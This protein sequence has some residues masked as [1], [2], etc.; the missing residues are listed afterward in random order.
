MKKVTDILKNSAA[1]ITASAA[2]I[3]S[4]CTIRITEDGIDLGG[5]SASSRQQREER[6]DEREETVDDKEITLEGSEE[7][8][9]TTAVIIGESVDM[10]ETDPAVADEIAAAGEP[11]SY[12]EPTAAAEVAAA[13]ATYEEVVLVDND[14]TDVTVADYNDITDDTSWD[15]KPGYDDPAVNTHLDNFAYEFT[16][17][18]EYEFRY[19]NTDRGYMTVDDGIG[20]TVVIRIG[21]NAYVF[22]MASNGY[23]DHQVGRTFLMGN[24]GHVYFYI[25]QSTYYGHATHV[26]ELRDDMI[27][28]IGS[29][30]KFAV[31]D[32]SDPN[33]FEGDLNSGCT[34]IFMSRLYRIDDNGMPYP[35]NEFYYFDSELTA[36]VAFVNDLTGNIIR[37]GVVTEDT[38]TIPAGTYIDLVKTNGCTYID[39]LYGSDLVRVDWSDEFQETADRDDEYYITTAI[40][41]HLLGYR[42]PWS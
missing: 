19:L 12:E 10:I 29:R 41:D 38:V 15:P 18:D 40:T 8:A 33:W 30:A 17:S 32:I 31:Y 16:Y 27:Y 9:G 13:E 2:L 24:N 35:V 26:Y 3:T 28:Y 39:V 22:P 20:D 34:Y 7:T 14:M 6:E 36:S 42:Y 11:A 37:G 25:G 21:G 5:S 23:T 4:G 1:L